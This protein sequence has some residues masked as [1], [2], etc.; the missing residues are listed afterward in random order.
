VETPEEGAAGRESR[1][2]CL[3]ARERAAESPPQLNSVQSPDEDQPLE[4]PAATPF[5]HPSVIE[6]KAVAAQSSCPVRI[7]TPCFEVCRE[8]SLLW[9]LLPVVQ[10]RSANR[11][12]SGMGGENRL[13]DRAFVVSLKSNRCRDVSVWNHVPDRD[14]RHRLGHT[15]APAMN[16]PIL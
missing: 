15:T 2:F 8:L 16:A 13:G 14:A 1:C 12:N 4:M 9:A 11:G 5:E 10:S 3:G 6:A 7:A